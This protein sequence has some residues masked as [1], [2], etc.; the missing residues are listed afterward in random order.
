MQ[1]KIKQSKKINKK[2]L[3]KK[4]IYRVIPNSYKKVL[5]ML[6]KQILET[7][8]FILQQKN[9]MHNFNNLKY[10]WTIYQKIEYELNFSELSQLIEIT[11][12]ILLTKYMSIEHHHFNN[13]IRLNEESEKMQ[14]NLKYFSVYCWKY[15]NTIM[16][17]KI[18]SKI[19]FDNFLIKK[20]WN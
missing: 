12:L 11:N 9:W 16:V 17:Q 19:F 6:K 15:L 14:M 3:K 8:Y 4:K 7:K 10:Y 18:F 2:F 5:F 13:Q 20:N 1:K